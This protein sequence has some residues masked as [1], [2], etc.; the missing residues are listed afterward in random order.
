MAY[1]L[2]AILGLVGISF[3]VSYHVFYQTSFLHCRTEVLRRTGLSKKFG[4]K[5]GAVTDGHC[6]CR[7]FFRQSMAGRI[8]SFLALM[9]G[10][11][12][13]SE[14]NNLRKSGTRMSLQCDY[15][16]S[17]VWEPSSFF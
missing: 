5:T 17:L 3:R 13:A 12:V 2:L 11:E 15:Q 1:G 14:V 9:R 8:N 6:T 16:V 7:P 10:A 4:K